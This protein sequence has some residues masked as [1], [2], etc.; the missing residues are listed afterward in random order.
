MTLTCTFKG[1]STREVLIPFEPPLVQYDELKPRMLEMKAVAQEQL[2]MV[3]F[4][5]PLMIYSGLII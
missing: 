2:G 4:R 1:G 3:S 5:E